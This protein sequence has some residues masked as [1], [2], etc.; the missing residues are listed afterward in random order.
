MEELPLSQQKTINQNSPFSLDILCPLV[1]VFMAALLSCATVE[2]VAEP[3]VVDFPVNADL[4]GIYL[5]QAF[6]QDL[7]TN[8]S[9]LL[10]GK[11]REVDLLLVHQQGIHGLRNF[12]QEFTVDQNT[13]QDYDL[14]FMGEDVLVDQKGQRLQRISLTEIVDYDPLYQII[15]AQTII[16]ELFTRQEYHSAADD[17]LVISGPNIVINDTRYALNLDNSFNQSGFDILTAQ[18]QQ[19]GLMIAGYK[20]YIYDLTG[21]ELGMAVQDPPLKFQF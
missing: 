11:G 4:L 21:V 15:L 19:L 9:P 13:Y 6:L 14:R 10:A 17:Y 8:K 3:A 12:S 2:E 20:I 16:N 7:Q 1:L 5:D 18:G